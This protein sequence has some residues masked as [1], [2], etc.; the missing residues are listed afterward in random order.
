MQSACAVL[1]FHLWPVWLYHIFLHCLVKSTISEKKK[2][3]EH[4]N[5][6]CDFLYDFR[7][8]YFLFKKNLARYYH[9][10]A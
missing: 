1:Y 3:I 10:Y 5:M 7:L 8:I 6:C 4:K 2:V 9:K